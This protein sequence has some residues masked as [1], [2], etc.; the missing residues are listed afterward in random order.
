MSAA[1]RARRRAKARLLADQGLSN[2]VVA[3]RVGVSES[4][5][6]RWRAEDRAVAAPETAPEPAPLHLPVEGDFAEDLAVL[7]EAGGTAREAVKL[8]V[9]LL[10]DAYRCGWDYGLYERTERPAV[11]VRPY[12]GRTELGP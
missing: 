5:V 9:Q 7:T 12:R 2:R 11:R 3:K 10:A 8:A 6:R 1:T 4:T